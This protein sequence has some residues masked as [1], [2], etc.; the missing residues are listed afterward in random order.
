MDPRKNKTHENGLG[1]DSGPFHSIY[2][3][4]WF[5]C[6]VCLTGA[7]GSYTQSLPDIIL[8]N[9]KIVTVDGNFSIAEAVAIKSDLIQDVGT[10]SEILEYSSRRT[11][12][13]D[14]QGKTVLPGLIDQYTVWDLRC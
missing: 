11:K 13:I 14:L 1:M 7:S 8:Y 2:K 10:N 12:M 3:I 6:F 5:L 4:A 9:G